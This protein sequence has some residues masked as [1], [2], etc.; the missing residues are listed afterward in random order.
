MKISYS[1]LKKFLNTKLTQKKLTE[2]FTQVGFECEVD[3]N[4]IE[5]DVTP[6]RG[7]ILS[8]MGLQREFCAFQSKIFKDSLKIT[9]LEIKSDKSVINKVDK[10]GCSNYHLMLIRGLGGLKT[11]D[12]NKRKFL[13]DAGI[14]L[15]NSLVDLGNYV[16]LEI[17]APMHIFDLDNLSLP[18]NVVFPE[19]NNLPF[20]IIGGDLKNIQQS[21]LTIQDQ[22]GVQAIAGIIGGEKTS[23]TNNTKNI[24]VEAAFFKPEKIVNQA[25]KYGLATDA[26]HR[27]ERGVD[28][29]IQKLALERYLYLLN[30]IADYENV[31][32]FMSNHA[33]PNKKPVTLNIQRFNSFSGLNLKSIEI[34]KILKHLE[35]H[36]VSETAQNLEFSIPSHRFDIQLEED[37]YEELLRCYGY[38]N[39][40]VNTPKSGP[41]KEPAS[42]NFMSNLRLGLVH[43]GF[44]ELIHLPFVSHETY[45]SLVNNS[46]EPAEL[47]NPIN[48]SEPL[49]RGSLFGALFSAVNSNIKKGYFSIKA[50]ESGN[51]FEKTKNSFSQAIHIAGLIYNHELKRTWGSKEF[52]YDFYSLKAEV[53]KLLKNLGFND[54][55]FQHAPDT[56]VFSS[57]ALEIFG[58]NVKVGMMGEIDLS[59]TQKLLKKPCYGFELYPE[60]MSENLSNIRIKKFSKF[61]SSSRDINIIIPKTFN[62]GEVEEKLSKSI[63]KIKYATAFHLINIFE[64]KGI[65]SGC[66]SMTLRFTFQSNSKSL[67]DSEISSGIEQISLMLIENFEASIRK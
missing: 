48:E 28:P 3:G 21:S 5:F 45:A 35:F 60:K 26:S 54:I 66:I 36:L 47:I 6:N 22:E 8:L 9:K 29:Q 16:M 41:K 18:I 51:V 31:E 63:K 34:K 44:T 30:E 57:N 32:C 17:G 2:V 62:Y 46:S 56:K 24:A 65:A 55:K 20:S 23:V 33:L 38:N 58:G 39:I 1:Y 67:L 59:S 27:F 4:I 37:L 11:L 14:P 12:M 40:P 53:I 13:T 15:I 43:A 10:H 42:N 7:D 49:M 64:G 52:G 50:F 25:R 19:S 61:P